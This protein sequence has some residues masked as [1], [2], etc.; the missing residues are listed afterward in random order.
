MEVRFTIL[1]HE[2]V[3]REDL[4][5]LSPE[6]KKRVRGAIEGKLVTAPEIF[7]KPLRVSLAGYRSLRVGDW[8][9]IFR[10]EE[11][12]VKILLIAHRS[13]VYERAVGRI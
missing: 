10:I 1:W 3:Q 8:R 2:K 13:V 6:M 7:G 5:Q 9:V 4:P 11:R 12:T